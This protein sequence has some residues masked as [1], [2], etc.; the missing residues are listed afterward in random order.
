M[1]YW[2]LIVGYIAA[3]VVV[4]LIVARLLDF[5]ERDR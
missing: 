2:L 3:S 5:R 4:G 1:T